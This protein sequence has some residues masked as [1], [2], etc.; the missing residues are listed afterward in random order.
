VAA[1]PAWATA[2]I[3]I[4]W[5]DWGGWFDHVKPP[6]AATWPG[7]GPAGYRNSQFRYGYR[8]PCL[9]VSPYA[10]PGINHT[11]YSHASVVK[12]CLRLFGLKAWGAPALQPGDRSGDLWESFDLASPPRLGLPSTTPR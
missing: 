11:F 5:D 8:V 2:A 4:N 1:G 12:F 10:R 6:L 7:S 3:L 9:V